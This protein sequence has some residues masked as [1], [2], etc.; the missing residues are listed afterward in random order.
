MSDN[1]DVLLRRRVLTTIPR[2]AAQMGISAPTVAS[3]LRQLEGLG[4]VRE[5]TGRRRDRVFVYDRYLAILNAGTTTP[6]T[7]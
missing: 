4:I 3:S 1:A 2:A 5:A 7:S 6:G